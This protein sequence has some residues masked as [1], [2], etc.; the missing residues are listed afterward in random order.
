MIKL[1]TKNSVIEINYL[2][3]LDIVEDKEST[4]LIVGNYIENELFA[5]DIEV[6]ESIK[7]IDRLI[8]EEL[9]IKF[10]EITFDE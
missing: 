4:I 5:I 1:H 6:R 10:S 2:D 3:I 8:E 9:D 7:E